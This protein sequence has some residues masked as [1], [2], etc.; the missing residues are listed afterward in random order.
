MAV[1]EQRPGDI[2]DEVTARA[3]EKA[4]L[5]AIIDSDVKADTGAAPHALFDLAGKHCHPRY[6]FYIKQLLKSYPNTTA[7]V[8]HK[9]A[10]ADGGHY[11]G[12]VR[13][14]I[15]DPAGAQDDSAPEADKEEWYKF[16]D[17]KVSVVTR[18]KIATL[19]GGGEDSTAYILLYRCV[20]G[21]Y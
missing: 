11:I 21:N 7:I 20:L 18:E 1:D 13:K 4:T 3:R 17:D 12:W 9:G 6:I 15:L 5:D 8:T 16:D 14:S 19:D 10:S 2:E